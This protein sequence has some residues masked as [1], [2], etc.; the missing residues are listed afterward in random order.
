[1]NWLFGGNKVWVFYSIRLLL[2]F[3][4]SLGET[5]FIEGV[6]RFFGK[7]TSVILFFLLLCSSGMYT[8]ST[9][10]VNSSLAMISVFFAYGMWMR[11]DNHFIGLLI[12][13]IAVV[14]EWP[15]VGVAFIPMG[16][17]CLYRRGF[18]KTL[19][20]AVVIVSLVLGVDLA[21]TYHFTHRLTIPAVNIVLYN[22]LGIGGSADVRSFPSIHV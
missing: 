9:S 11:F 20:Y 13:A 22:V 15:F 16:L 8:A 14:C 21:I 5:L 19:L 3:I 10:F 18:K 1:M 17:D 12:G 2:A 6:R 7:M 4:C